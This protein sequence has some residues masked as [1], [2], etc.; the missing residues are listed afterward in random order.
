MSTLK[1]PAQPT[2][3][4]AGGNSRKT[5]N[6]NFGGATRTRKTGANTTS[7]NKTIDL[8]YF[9][10]DGI[11]VR[12]KPLMMKHVEK[13]EVRDEN[14]EP[15]SHDQSRGESNL[16]LKASAEVDKKKE[17]GSQHSQMTSSMVET[18][19]DE[20]E[21][22]RL[23]DEKKKS[24]KKGISETELDMVINVEI[25]E[26]KTITLLHIPGICVNH[27]TEEAA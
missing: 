23:E 10:V 17:T 24:K 26:T 3:K 7:G 1:P 4:L 20:R 27:D 18:S 13:Q 5:G 11:N 8:N 15:Q 2:G 21:K 25:K 9:M 19:E 6:M 14:E 12:P 22:K 16:E